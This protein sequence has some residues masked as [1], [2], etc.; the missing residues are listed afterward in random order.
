MGDQHN[1]EELTAPAATAKQLHLS[2]ATL[3]KYSLIVEHVTGKPDYYARTKQRAR[4]YSKQDVQDLNDFHKLA[5]NNGLT[6]QEAAMQVFAVSDKKRKSPIPKKQEMMTAS[7]AVKLLNALQQTISE[8]NTAIK[9]LQEQLDRIEK[10]NSELLA[11]QDQLHQKQDD[12]ADFSALP[13][14]SGI[15]TEEAVSQ[16]D[17]QSTDKLTLEEKRAQVRQD[18]AKPSEQLHEEIL[19]KAKENAEKHVNDNIHRTLE[20]MQLEP[21]KKHWWQRFINM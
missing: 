14:I 18:E 6:L 10:Q 15:V 2:V 8:Q 3:R 12:E 1:F 19:T 17:Q 21:Q 9:N 16:S 7:Q 13:D 5:Q 11:K 20:D 4:L